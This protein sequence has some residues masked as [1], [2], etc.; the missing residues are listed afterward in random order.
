MTNQIEPKQVECW[1]LRQQGHTLEQ[2]AS[3]LGISV[4]TAQRY[5]NKVDDWVGEMPEVR[6]GKDRLKLLIP[7]A[8]NRYEASLDDTDRDS[9]NVAKDVLSTHAIVNAK[10]E[11][12]HNLPQL[13][14]FV[15]MY[16]RAKEL[17]GTAESTQVEADA[18]V[19]D[20]GPLDGVGGSPDEET[21]SI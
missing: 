13:D 21:D 8:L 4:S 12:D 9:Y 15:S 3:I 6:A 1:L 11:V 19:D 10:T 2:V 14:Q 20:T 18:T 7:K 5:G 17:A 16:N